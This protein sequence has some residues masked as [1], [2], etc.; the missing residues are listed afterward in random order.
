[1]G[2]RVIRDTDK[3]VYQPAIHSDRV[4]E[5]WKIGQITGRPM[6]VVL[7]E[8][9]RMYVVQFVC[10]PAWK[11]VGDPEFD[12]VEKFAEKEQARRDQEMDQFEDGSIYG[13]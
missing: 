13:F 12:A 1:M 5:L 11:T 3:R 8:A 9:I 2:E 6:T 7:D 4:S 10:T